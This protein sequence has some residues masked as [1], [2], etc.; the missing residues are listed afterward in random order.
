MDGTGQLRVPLDTIL[1]H[2]IARFRQVRLSNDQAASQGIILR[3]LQAAC[4]FVGRSQGPKDRRALSVTKEA[5]TGDHHFTQAGFKV[6][7]G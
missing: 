4:Q 7:L 5:L 1:A 2:I 6:R 3:V